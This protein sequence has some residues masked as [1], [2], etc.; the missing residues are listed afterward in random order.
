MAQLT[1]PNSHFLEPTKIQDPTFSTTIKPPPPKDPIFTKTTHNHPPI[2]I[3]PHSHTHTEFIK[4][5]KRTQNLIDL[6]NTKSNKAKPSTWSQTPRLKLEANDAKTQ[7][8]GQICWH[9]SWVCLRSTRNTYPFLAIWTQLYTQR[10]V[11]I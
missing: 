3:K 1:Q 8:M 6:P 11:S 7:W 9:S 2:H 10:D 5:K 4:K